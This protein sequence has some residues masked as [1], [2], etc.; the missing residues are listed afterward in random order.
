MFINNS[1][2][3]KVLL[4]HADLEILSELLGKWVNFLPFLPFFLGVIKAVLS[5][6]TTGVSGD[7]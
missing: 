1:E 2:I 3:P 5:L 4:V 6:N 7:I